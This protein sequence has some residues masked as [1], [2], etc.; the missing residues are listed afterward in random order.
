MLKKKIFL[1]RG[2]YGLAKKRQDPSTKIYP[3]LDFIASYSYLDKIQCG[4][5]LLFHFAVTFK[6]PA[7]NSHT[8]ITTG[9]VSTS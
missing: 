7:E 8:Y 3:I 9:R 2:G 1:R 4:K 6:I 5:T